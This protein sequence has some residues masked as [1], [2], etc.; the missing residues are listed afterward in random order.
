MARYDQV[1]SPVK[2]CI[3]IKVDRIKARQDLPLEFDQ[4]AAVSAV[5]GVF[6]SGR[7][8]GP[9]FAIREMKVV[10]VSQVFERSFGFGDVDHTNQKI[11]IAELPRGDVSIK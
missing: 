8:V 3:H 5:E 6:V 11:Q 1:R 10:P 2:D 7:Q 4:I 9:I